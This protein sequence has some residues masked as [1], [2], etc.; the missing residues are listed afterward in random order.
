MIF[1]V[2]VTMGQEKILIRMLMKKAQKEKLPVYSIIYADGVK[3]YMFVEA[4]DENTVISLINGVKNVK[5]MLKRSVPLDEVVKL[6]EKKEK[7]RAKVSVG[8][9]VEMTSGP[10]KGERA[11]VVAVDHAKDEI[12]VELLDVAVP[13][14]VSAK[15]RM[16]KLIQSAEDAAEEM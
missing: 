2:R 15:T 16:A 12:T 3:G 6:V 11:K 8:D 10:F 5:G 4:K 9:I 1:I 7:E 14:P 13:V